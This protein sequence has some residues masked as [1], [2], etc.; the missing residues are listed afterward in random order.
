M[1]GFFHRVAP[2]TSTRTPITV[3]AGERAWGVHI[4]RW[5][6]QSPNGAGPFHHSHLSRTSHMVV[7][8]S[9]GREVLRGCATLGVLLY[10]N[11]RRG[12]K[13][14]L[15]IWNIYK[16]ASVFDG[17]DTG[18]KWIKKKKKAN[19]VRFGFYI[20]AVEQ[21][22]TSWERLVGSRLGM[23]SNAGQNLFHWWHG[24]MRV[25]GKVWMILVVS[26]V[27][28]AGDCW[29]WIAISFTDMKTHERFSS[30]L[31]QY[32]VTPKFWCSWEKYKGFCANS[33]PHYTCPIKTLFA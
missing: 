5:I 12:G 32:E 26:C 4:L 13:K 31:A 10:K 21:W 7:P 2:L 8:N 3:A 16:M 11:G 23:I 20:C 14:R 22:D 17:N 28:A 25:W 18:I 24:A 15:S 33:F 29:G 27:G 19:V 6:L 30:K 9:W 1:P